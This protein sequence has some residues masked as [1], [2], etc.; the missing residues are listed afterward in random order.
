MNNLK[1]FLRLSLLNSMVN[2]LPLFS[3]ILYML[4]ISKKS[5]WILG[6]LVKEY[7]SPS[8]LPYYAILM[9]AVYMFLKECLWLICSPPTHTFLNFSSS[10]YFHQKMSK[11]T[12]LFSCFPGATERPLK[13]DRTLG[14]FKPRREGVKIQ[15]KEVTE[16]VF[17]Q[18]NVLRGKF[19]ISSSHEIFSST[20][21]LSSS[22]PS[23]PSSPA[24]EKRRNEEVSR[25]G[26]WS[27]PGGGGR[28]KK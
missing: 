13:G 18:Q 7:H 12:K 23:L 16:K 2:Y 22:Y 8:S 15:A 1:Y 4:N 14:Y 5:E 24:Q 3:F 28:H 21:I 25:K 10:N 9:L 11:V 17:S 27:V 19:P 6:T 26:E 20:E